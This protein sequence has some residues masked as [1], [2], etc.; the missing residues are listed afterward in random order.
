MR[1]LPRFHN[2]REKHI[3]SFEM[4]S[5]DSTPYEQ[6]RFRTTFVPAVQA[7][8]HPNAADAVQAPQTRRDVALDD[9]YV[10]SL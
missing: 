2:G 7:R 5:F 10:H 1:Y 6:R 3:F 4:P 8:A 9:S